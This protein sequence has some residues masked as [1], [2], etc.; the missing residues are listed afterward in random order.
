MGK[1][2]IVD[3]TMNLKNKWKKALSRENFKVLDAVNSKQLFS[4]L[5]T[6]EIDL[7]IIEL[8]L[9]SEHGYYIIKRLKE[10]PIYQ[11]IPIMVVSAERRR[12]SIQEVIDI[13]IVDYLIKPVDIDTLVKRV[14]RIMARLDK[15]VKTAIV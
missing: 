13:G 5:L 6:E 9:G 2:I 10:D 12:A 15:L 7:I 4:A 11:T 3:D 8:F 1:I 14:K